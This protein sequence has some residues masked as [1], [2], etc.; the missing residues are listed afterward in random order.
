VSVAWRFVAAPRP[1]NGSLRPHYRARGS[2]SIATPPFDYV[3]V[4]VQHLPT[5]YHYHVSLSTPR[6]SYHHRGWRHSRHVIQYLF[7]RLLHYRLTTR[8]L[9]GFNTLVKRR[10]IT[11]GVGGVPLR[12]YQTPSFLA[13]FAPTT[14]LGAPPPSLRQC[15]ITLP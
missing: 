15:S 3:T 5:V 1:H 9:Q 6:Y 11:L 8:T 13:C 7:V 4:T 10:V 14:G 2:A 12:S